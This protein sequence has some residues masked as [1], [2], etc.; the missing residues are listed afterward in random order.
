MGDPQQSTF[1][2]QLLEHLARAENPQK[3]WIDDREKMFGELREVQGILDTVAVLDIDSSTIDQLK[4]GFENLQVLLMFAH[5]RLQQK[6]D[7]ETA[8]E[9]L[10]INEV[11]KA[12]RGKITA[13]ARS[14]GWSISDIQTLFEPTGTF[15]W[16]ALKDA[17]DVRSI[18]HPSAGPNAPQQ[19]PAT[20]TGTDSRQPVE[21]SNFRGPKQWRNLLKQA[22]KE[23]GK[24]AWSDWRQKFGD[25]IDGEKKSCRITREL[26]ESWGLQ[27]DEFKDDA[28]PQVAASSSK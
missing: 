25:A 15:A 4:R 11:A 27:L 23:I 7:A 2:D 16:N 26:A 14:L 17:A 13:V 3:A 28:D 24:R 8:Q 10:T 12:C 22:G 21:W 20:C 1:D 9:C 5:N 19:G 18:K 6:C